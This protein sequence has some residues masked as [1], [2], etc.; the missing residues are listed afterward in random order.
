MVLHIADRYPNVKAIVHAGHSAGGQLLSRYSF[1]T[2][3]YDVLRARGIYVRYVIGN[4]SSMLYFDRQR[5]DLVAGKGFVDYRS[6]IPVLAEGECKDFNTYKYGLDGLVPYMTRRPVSAMLAAFRTRDLYLINGTADV[7]PMADGLDRDCPGLLQGRFR[8]ER[9]QRYY[10]YLGHFFGPEI[11]KNKFL[12]LVP[13]VAHAGGEMFRSAAGK[14]LIF[15]DADSAAKAIRDQDTTRPPAKFTLVIHGGGGVRERAEF[16]AKPGLEKAYR[17]GLSDALKAG[18]QVLAAGG[19]AVEAV[20]A[21]INVMEDSPLFNAGKGASYTTD[22]TVELDASIMDGRTMKAG[23]VAVARRIKNPI[24]LARIVLEKTPHV[25]VAG[26]G[27][28]ALAQEMGVPFVPESYFYTEE[29]WNEL[30]ER[31]NLKVPVRHADPED[32]R[33]AARGCER[34]QVVGH[35][36][37]GGARRAGQPGRRHIHRR[38]HHQ[39]AGR[40]GDSPIIGASTYAN[41]DIVAV[42]TTGL[43]EKHMVLLTSKEIAS[44]MKYKGLSVQEAADNAM[45][46]Q[47]KALGGSG[48][49]IALDKNGNFATPYT[50]N[51][52]YRGW[53]RADGVI[54][55]RIYDK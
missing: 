17:D 38:T 1:G 32:R 33:T 45:K 9:G 15:I 37:R 29:K 31:M 11:Y 39:A 41:N 50:E 34:H 48:G 6:R 20:E 2:P 19:S 22:G 18:H 53:V 3:V 54:E 10:E 35:G 47:L 43:G 4:P 26:E 5:P 24:S 7:D 13:G 27:V 55:V 46:V 40:V 25:L 14:P 49:A 16:A 44:L 21:A 8:L 51:G 42:S 52:M 36:R 12:V 28:S 23:A 30:Q